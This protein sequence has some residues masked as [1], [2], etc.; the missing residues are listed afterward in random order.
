M[1]RRCGLAC[2]RHGK[3]RVSWGCQKSTC[4]RTITTK[5]IMSPATAS[6]SR[7]FDFSPTIF[8]NQSSPLRLQSK[9]RRNGGGFTG[10]VE[11]VHQRAKI[12]SRRSTLRGFG[13][14]A[15]SPLNGLPLDSGELLTEGGGQVL[16]LGKSAVQLILQRHGIIR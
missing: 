16:G 2:F 6:P 1:E 4:C 14:D 11:R 13:D 15:A 8:S 5:P 7:S 3:P 10:S 9:R 12:Q